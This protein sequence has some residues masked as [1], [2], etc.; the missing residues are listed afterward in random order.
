MEHYRD[1]I[2][3]TLNFKLQILYINK[4]HMLIKF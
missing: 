2:N 1:F 3:V 4:I